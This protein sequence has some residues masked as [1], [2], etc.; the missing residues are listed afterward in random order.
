MRKI[1]YISTLLYLAFAACSNTD[2]T[3]SAVFRNA[4]YTGNDARFDKEID[5]QRQYFNPI[6]S[7]FYPD[8]S[9][10]RKGDDF[11]L[12]N[13][14]FSYYP[15]IPI[16]HSRDLVNWTQIGFVLNRPSQLKLDGIRLSGGIYAPAIEYN[17]HND[18]FYVITTCVDGIGNFLVKTDDPFKGEWSEPITLPAVG[19][20]DPS[21]FFDEDGSGY[22]VNNDA[23]QGE[24]EYD[25]HRAIWLHRFDPA[26]D[27]TFGEAKMIIDGGV[28]KSQKPIWIEGPHLYKINGKYYLMCAEG[29]TSVNH[30]EVIFS[31]NSL[32][33][34]FILY[35]N[36]PILTQKDLPEDR[37]EIV[38]STGHADIIETADG[39]WYAV[40]L[41]CRPYK[42]NYY[43]TGR[44]TFLL[45]V[46]WE[47]GFPVILPQGESV[48]VV[49][50]KPDLS[51]APNFLTGNFVWEDRFGSKKLGYDWLFVRTPIDPWWRIED[52][53][54]KIDAIQRR[55]YDIDNPAY[56][57]RRIQH[58]DFEFSVEMDFVPQSETELA[59]ICCFQNEKYNIILGKTMD[60][61]QPVIVLYLADGESVPARLY[62]QAIPDEYAATPVILSIKAENTYLRFDVTYVDGTRMTVAEEIDT[63][64]LTTEKAGGFVGAT[65]GMYA[66]SVHPGNN[67]EK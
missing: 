1:V 42:G 22:I 16:F 52:D 23:P 46:T 32:D 40:F 20:I 7:G 63:A 5:P 58:L 11:F 37:P 15:G 66:T 14:S 59:G 34:S 43:Y 6:L 64:F 2:K 56:I 26:T 4:V 12:V 29:G 18:T 51:P 35:E 28:D 8:P 13:S 60:G 33:E 24:P 38:T 44:E 17:P 47:N 21:L 36:N 67:F 10:C 45:P 30:R 3:N 57:G 31:A 54:M 50:D 62:S 9:I 48:P 55:I 65:V 19:G 49:V 39:E 27:Q 25:G 53:A 41:G 61:D